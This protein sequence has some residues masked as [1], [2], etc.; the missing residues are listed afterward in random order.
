MAATHTLPATDVA[1][2]ANKSMISLFNGSGSGIT[3]KPYRIF[4]MNNQLNA[5]TGVLTNLELR[6]ISASS[7]GTTLTATK[8]DT[9]SS[10]LPAQV[11][12]ATNASVTPTDLYRRILWSTDEP[13]AGTLTLDELQ[14]FGPLCCI[15]SQG[16]ADSYTEPL[17]LAEGEGITIINGGASAGL[18]DFFIE[19]T[20]A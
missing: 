16:Y 2:S 7:G 18:A 14:L 13:S 5:V 19:F 3:I 9:N 17:T 6:K 11:L 8:H 10:N 20:A 15:W 12:L 1:F 4:V